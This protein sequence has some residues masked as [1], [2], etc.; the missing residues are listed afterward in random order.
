MPD[1]DTEVVDLVPEVFDYF[2]FY[3]ADA[4]PWLRAATQFALCRQR[5]PQPFAPRR[6]ALRHH[7]RRSLAAD[8][9]PPGSVNLYTREFFALAKSRLTEGGVFCLWVQRPEP[10]ERGGAA[11]S[12][13]SPMCFPMAASW[14]QPSSPAST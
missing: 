7:L 11:S 8:L 2:R 13:A 6:P 3:H 12:T 4:W 1:L 10:R 9:Q 5:W 14:E